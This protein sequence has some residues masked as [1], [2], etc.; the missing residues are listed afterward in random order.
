M[1][2]CVIPLPLFLIKPSHSISFRQLE[3][4]VLHSFRKNKFTIV[5]P[6]SV[7]ESFCVHVRRERE[8]HGREC[9]AQWSWI[10]GL[11]GPT[12]PTWHLEMRDFLV[13]PQ[14]EYAMDGLAF[15]TALEDRDISTIADATEATFSIGE[16]ESFYASEFDIPKVLILYGSETGTAES[17]ALDLKKQLKLLKPR[18]MTL[19]EAAG[20][21][22]VKK[23]RITHVLCVCSTFGEGGPPSNAG[24]FMKTPI[25]KD[26][27]LSTKFAV[28]AL[29][30]TLYPEFCQAGMELNKLLL[31]FGL[32]QFVDLVKA[33]EVGR[34]TAAQ[35]EWLNVVK[36]K[37]L[38]P[39]LEDALRPQIDVAWDS[40][41]TDV[42]NWAPGDSVSSKSTGQGSLCIE[43]AKLTDTVQK[44]TFEV[45]EQSSYESGDHLVVY[46]V[47]CERQVDEFLACFSSELVAVASRSKEFNESSGSLYSDKNALEWAAA[48]PVSLETFEGDES[49]PAD[50]FFD[51]P[52]T[53]STVLKSQIDLATRE[54]SFTS[55]LKLMKQ[56]LDELLVSLKG[57]KASL[58]KVKSNPLVDEFLALEKDVCLGKQTMEDV[59]ATFPNIVLFFSRF[60]SVFLDRFAETQLGREG[61][62]PLISLADF[63]VLAPRLQP[64]FYSISSSNKISPNQVTITVG[65]LSTM[66]SKGVPIKGVCSHYLASMKAG[67]DRARIGIRHSTFRLPNVANYPTSAPLIMVGAGT[68]L[69]PMMGFLQDRALD[70]RNGH[71]IGSI[72]LFFGCRDES[73]FIYEREIQQYQNDGLIRLHL[74]LSRSK[75]APKTYV[76]HKI[77][78]MGA[79][80]ADLL[81][82]KD[83]HYYV[84]G[85][86]RMANDCH[87]ACVQ[88]LRKH[89]RMSRVA[90]VHVLNKMRMEGRWQTDVWGIVCE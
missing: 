75:R 88:L 52:T 53:L 67:V 22:V 32:E 18:L 84:C 64:R 66:T 13:K 63:L 71:E 46:P 68:G 59:I 86:A 87:E 77:E 3:R 5:D 56:R 76:Q 55:L 23:R 90:A 43:N 27:P 31:S 73:C 47:N 72:D 28:L 44:I 26:V 80:G 15:H 42:L 83:T 48:Q 25:N 20:L 62:A 14:Y 9:P 60:R 70:K 57:E 4:S 50:V 16:S 65:I 41:C 10:G 49:E 6:H 30:S 61:A 33:D 34:G 38:P 36:R 12:N 37:L 8:Q 58:V 81:L 78:A 24:I 2:A 51:M 82:R 29:G 7:G 74:A 17:V 45:P 1:V 69:A 40:T 79:A 19:D 89:G 39:Y 85:D 54:S 35:A 11:V 21:A